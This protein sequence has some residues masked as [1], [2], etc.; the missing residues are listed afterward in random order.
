MIVFGLQILVT[1]NLDRKLAL[2]DD[3]ECTS[4][5][6]SPSPSSSEKTF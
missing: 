5:P 6:S 3:R 4:V 1:V 2:L